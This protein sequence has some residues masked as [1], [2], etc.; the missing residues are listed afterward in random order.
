M[1]SNC[2]MQ[3]TDPTFSLAQLKERDSQTHLLVLTLM[4][5]LKRLSIPPCTAFAYNEDA[6]S[7]W[8]PNLVLSVMINLTPSEE[9]TSI[10]EDDDYIPFMITNYRQDGKPFTELHHNIEDVVRELTDILL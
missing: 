10:P 9:P 5:S 7:L 4:D 6:Y 1:D 8:W 2:V 3:M